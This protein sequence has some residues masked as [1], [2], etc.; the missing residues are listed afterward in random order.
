MRFTSACAAASPHH[1]SI[2]H[3][4]AAA[5]LLPHFGGGLL[6]LSVLQASECRAIRRP[7]QNDLQPGVQLGVVGCGALCFSTNGPTWGS[8]PPVFVDRETDFPQEYN[9]LQNGWAIQSH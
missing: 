2:R 3:V 8:V 5:G 9:F 6:E 1:I 7:A 4:E